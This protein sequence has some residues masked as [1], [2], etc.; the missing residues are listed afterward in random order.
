MV[1]F[2][3]FFPQSLPTYA[4]LENQQDSLIQERLQHKIIKGIL[5]ALLSKI[6]RLK[7]TPLNFSGHDLIVA[8]R[9]DSNCI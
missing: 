5:L 7:K 8:E 3:R 2:F 4:S 6:A 9:S 1:Y